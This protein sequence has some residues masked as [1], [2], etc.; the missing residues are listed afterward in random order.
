M[1]SGRFA[2]HGLR[3]FS[4]LSRPKT[5]WKTWGKPCSS[6]QYSTLSVR[7]YMGRHAARI[8]LAP[9]YDCCYDNLNEIHKM[10]Q[11]GSARYMSWSW[12]TFSI[13]TS[14]FK[15]NGFNVW[16]IARF[17]EDGASFWCCCCFGVRWGGKPNADSRTALQC[18]FGT[19]WKT[20][21]A[22]QPH[23]TRQEQYPFNSKHADAGGRVENCKSRNLKSNLKNIWWRK[24]ITVHRHGNI[25]FF[26]WYLC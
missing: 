4:I 22:G 12:G 8:F 9:S 1:E 7:Y 15:D 14:S 11:Q 26:E 23:K 17:S 2:F 24:S 18:T 6:L 19:S 10:G 13:R 5:V 25:H 3:L 20:D 16:K 21:S